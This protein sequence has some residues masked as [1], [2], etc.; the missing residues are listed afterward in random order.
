MRASRHT[1][2]SSDGSLQLHA[3]AHDADVLVAMLLGPSHTAATAPPPP[4]LPWED[5]RNADRD[6]TALRGYKR[7]VLACLSRD[8]ASRPSAQELLAAWGRM[9]DPATEL[10]AAGGVGGAAA[11]TP[12]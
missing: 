7:S 9:F 12:C 6:T 8:A 4:P 10:H 1:Q 11:P 3:F 2:L 5:P